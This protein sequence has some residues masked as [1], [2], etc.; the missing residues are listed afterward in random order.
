MENITKALLI[1]AAILMVILILSAIMVAYNE[2]SEFYQK[3]HEYTQMEQIQKFNSKFENYNGN[4]IRGNELISIINKVMDYNNFQ[5]DKKD[6]ERIILRIDL[7]GHADELSYDGNSKKFKD[8]ISNNSDDNSIKEVSELSA[9]LTSEASGIPEITD[10]KLQKLASEIYNIVPE[11]V[12]EEKRA[13]KL[14]KILGYKVENN[15]NCPKYN[16]NILREVKLATYAYYEL[17]QFKRAMF[18][19]TDIFYD[20]DTGRVNGMEFVVET[21][22]GMIKFK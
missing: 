11:K 14:T 20:Q 10:V 16:T 4:T 2:M 5:S 8:I 17:T 3:E 19:C 21:E 9:K 7:L 1:A 12:D 15:G 18:T 13:E 22:N 6:Y